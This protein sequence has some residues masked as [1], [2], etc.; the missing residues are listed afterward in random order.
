MSSGQTHDR[1][2]LCSLPL[3]VLATHRVVQSLWLTLWVALGFL[4]GGLM[5]GPDLDIHSVQYKRW[6]W[7]RWIWL[8]YRGSLRHRSVWSH[9]PII[10]TTVRVI[11]A[12]G[13]LALGLVMVV[14]VLNGLQRTALSWA[15][16]E[17][18]LG[19]FISTHW[20]VGVALLAGLELGALSHYTADW[21]SSSRKRRTHGHQ[22]SNPARPRPRR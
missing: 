6:G 1:I 9:G 17:T 8:P 15:D 7:L 20:P 21:L 14:D 10:G 4:I 12:A 13:W 16:L 18:S 2:T 11:Y 5:L 22:R 19:S 3:V